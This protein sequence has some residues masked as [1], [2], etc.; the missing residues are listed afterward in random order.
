MHLRPRKVRL[1]KN[2]D[3]LA[4]RVAIFVVPE[5]EFDSFCVKKRKTV[6]E[7]FLREI[8][9]VNDVLARMTLYFDEKN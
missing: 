3:N 4:I 7:Q 9:T 8:T 5:Q 1:L 2:V 6:F